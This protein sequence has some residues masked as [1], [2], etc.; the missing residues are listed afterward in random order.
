MQGFQG[1]VTLCEV[2]IIP[3]D[4]A[5]LQLQDNWYL[6]HLPQ[7]ATCQIHR[8]NSSV[9]KSSSNTVPIEYTFSHLFA[10]N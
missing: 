8:L 7:A 1:A 3:E 9:L 2:E 5:V 10:C 6:V 4:E